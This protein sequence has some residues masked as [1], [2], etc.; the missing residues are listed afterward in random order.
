MPL[1][2]AEQKGPQV[3]SPMKPFHVLLLAGIAMLLLAVSYT[4]GAGHAASST[5]TLLN[6]RRRGSKV[7]DVHIHAQ[8]CSKHWHGVN[9]CGMIRCT[10]VQ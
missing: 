3:M 6:R 10:A 5:R 7:S 8:R 4:E 9:S 2:Y 1:P